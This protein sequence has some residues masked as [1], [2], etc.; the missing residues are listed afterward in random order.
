MN[1]PVSPWPFIGMAGMACSFFLYAASVLFAPW[2]AVVLLLAVWVLLLLVACVWW[3]PYPRRVPG[4][5][6]VAVLVWVGAVAL[7]SA[8]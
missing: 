3:T 2:W 4:V 5:A 6:V 7:I 1:E 8:G